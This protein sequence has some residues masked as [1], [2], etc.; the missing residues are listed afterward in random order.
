MRYVRAGMDCWLDGQICDSRFHGW[1]N[2]PEHDSCLTFKW[3]EKRQHHRLYG[4]LCN[5]KP[6]SNR[7][8]RLCVLV[9]H[10]YKNDWATDPT[11][12]NRCCLLQQ[13]FRTTEAIAQVYPEYGETYL[14]QR[15]ISKWK[16]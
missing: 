14:K 15:G 13:D 6:A 8:F 12:L 11:T 2:D 7:S 9:F 1:P 5:P 4:F 10:A 3:K 16:Q